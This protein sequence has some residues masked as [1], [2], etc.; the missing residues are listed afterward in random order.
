MLLAEIG[1]EGQRR[2]GHA[3]AAVAGDGLAHQIATTYVHRAGVGGVAAGP[4]DESRWA[5]SF[6][7]HPAPRAVVT[8]SRAALAAMRDALSVGTSTARKAD[9]RP[10]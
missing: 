10:S 4:I 1:E 7:E 6:L 8:G 2:L 5:P 9:P 3:V